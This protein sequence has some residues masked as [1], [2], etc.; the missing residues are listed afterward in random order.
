MTAAAMVKA[1]TASGS[2]PSDGHHG[3]ATLLREDVFT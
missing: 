3:E 1:T 2:T